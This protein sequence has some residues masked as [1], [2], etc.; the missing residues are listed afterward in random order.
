MPASD[1]GAHEMDIT[2]ASLRNPAAVAVIVAMV[3]VFG[4]IAL[5]DL[6][7]AALAAAAGDHAARHRLANVEQA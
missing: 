2:R 1:H 5:R 7:Q 3:A 4:L 6:V